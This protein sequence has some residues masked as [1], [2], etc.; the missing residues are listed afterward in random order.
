MSKALGIQQ[1]LLH[2][3]R[4][5]EKLKKTPRVRVAAKPVE[6]PLSLID[7]PDEVIWAIFMMNPFVVY[8]L[9]WTC[10]R[11]RNM[12]WLGYRKNLDLWDS[13]MPQN[14]TLQKRL[15]CMLESQ[16]YKRVQIVD[17]AYFFADLMRYSLRFANRFH[18]SLHSSWCNA[19]T[20]DFFFCDPGDKKS[21][22]HLLAEI[23]KVTR[24]FAISDENLKIAM[25]LDLLLFR[26]LTGV[27]YWNS[28]HFNSLQKWGKYAHANGK[29]KIRDF[30]YQRI[31]HRKKCIKS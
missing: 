21:R 24:N 31:M 28:M 1:L 16:L 8:S 3:L 30:L 7:L 18:N 5:K 15:E 17:I 23:H 27:R 10:V 13:F 26:R 9:A 25:N 6:I 12:F 2:R 19:H 11:F 29:S 20:I 22:L 4:Q 14:P